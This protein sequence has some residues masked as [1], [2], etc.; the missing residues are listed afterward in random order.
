MVEFAQRVVAR[1]AWVI[2]ALWASD[3]LRS[4]LDW[5]FR[6]LNTLGVGCTLAELGPG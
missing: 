2:S 3:S 5:M 4:S 1:Y 6:L